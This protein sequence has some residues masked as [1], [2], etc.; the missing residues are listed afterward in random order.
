[1]QNETL[2]ETVPAALRAEMARSGVQKGEVA[3]KVRHADSWLYRRLYATAAERIEITLDD[4][5]A[6]CAALELEPVI[7]FR[8]VTPKKKTTAGRGTGRRSRT[9]NPSGERNGQ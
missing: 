1:M 3:R 7:E 8:P 4:L 2:S 5:Q 9:P 6:I